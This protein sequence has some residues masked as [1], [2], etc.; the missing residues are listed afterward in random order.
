MDAWFVRIQRSNFS[1]V[2]K[3]FNTDFKTKTTEDQGE[4]RYCFIREHK[5]F[6]SKSEDLTVVRDLAYIVICFCAFL[7]YDEVSS[8]KCKNVSLKNGYVK[9]YIE[10]S[11]NDQF[12]NGMEVV[13][14]EL[15]SICCPVKALQK[16]I[17][18]A[19]IDLKS[20]SFLFKPLYKA[21]KRAGL[22]KTNKKISYTRAREAV[23]F[24]FR[25]ICPK[26][27]LGLHSLRAGGATSAANSRIVNERCLQR[28]GRWRASS[29]KD[30]YI[31]DSLESRLN[32]S[33][34]LGL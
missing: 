10:K 24:R 11:K 8:L 16:Y 20:D 25:E 28:H 15:S 26:L 5:K 9:L 27:N 19:K 22:I 21:K 3:K 18:L 13:V 29:S 2:C 12:R 31:K 33:Q 1:P 7:R 14:S 4:K 17:R 32:V 34:N 23:L 6:I 30:G